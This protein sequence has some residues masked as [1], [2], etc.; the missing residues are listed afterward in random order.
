MW[1][2]DVWKK[3][4]EKSVLIKLG[5][6][7]IALV[8]HWKLGLNLKKMGKFMVMWLTAMSNVKCHILEKLLK[9]QT[10]YLKKNDFSTQGILK[11]GFVSVCKA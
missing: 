4:M 10:N 6:L 2:F 5:F 9:M 7:T 11:V 3:K 1:N 8:F